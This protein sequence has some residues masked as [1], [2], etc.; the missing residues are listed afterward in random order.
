L[1]NINNEDCEIYNLLIDFTRYKY[2]SVLVKVSKR[3]DQ[4]LMPHV[5]KAYHYFYLFES[6]LILLSDG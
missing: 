1:Q 6:N 4:I 5:E 3:L 2:Q